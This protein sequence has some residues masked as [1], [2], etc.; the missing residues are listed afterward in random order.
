MQRHITP[1]F[2]GDDGSPVTWGVALIRVQNERCVLTGQPLPGEAFQQLRPG[3]RGRRVEFVAEKSDNLKNL[4]VG[5]FGAEL[6]VQ[7]L[8]D[9]GHRILPVRPVH[10]VRPAGAPGRR[11]TSPVPFKAAGFDPPGL[12]VDRIQVDTATS[13]R[14]R[15][16]TSS[17]YPCNRTTG[18]GPATLSKIQPKERV[19]TVPHPE[20]TSHTSPT[21]L[22]LCYQR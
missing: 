20:Q 7:A 13:S 17:R 19:T 5:V 9:V 6:A 3:F 10:T 22:T 11:V 2:G 15:M 1:L 12:A 4:A 18:S 14:G 8:D 16:Q 21:C